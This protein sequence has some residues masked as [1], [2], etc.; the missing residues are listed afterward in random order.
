MLG[1]WISIG[2][3]KVDTGV[4]TTPESRC[5]LRATV[6]SSGWAVEGAGRRGVPG[7]IICD[8]HKSVSR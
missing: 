7:K 4:E 5:L 3:S 8:I 6:G 2:A 1:G